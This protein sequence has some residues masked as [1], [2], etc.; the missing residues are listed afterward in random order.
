MGKITVTLHLMFVR[1]INLRDHIKQFP[2]TEH[3]CLGDTLQ[4]RHNG[5]DWV[6]NHQRLDYLL[7]LLF[8]HGLKK[9][10]KLN[11]TGLCDGNPPLTDGFPSQRAISISWRYN[12]TL[13]FWGHFMFRVAGQ[14]IISLCKCNVCVYI[15]GKALIDQT[16]RYRLL[17]IKHVS[18]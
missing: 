15:I 11:V 16:D 1:Q 8:R 18:A 6:S 7:K 9:T 4:W 12:G 2:R 13:L 17:N 3:H 10:S 5:H 14:R